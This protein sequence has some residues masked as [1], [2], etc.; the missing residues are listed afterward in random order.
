MIPAFDARGN[1]PPGIHFAGW[2]EF[3]ARFGQTAR[4]RFL[5]T[6]LKAALRALQTAGCP[7]VYVDGSFVTNKPAPGDFDACWSVEGVQPERLDSVLLDF[8]EG[9]AAQKAAFGGELFPAQLPEGVSGRTFLTF[10]Q[11][12]RETGLAKGIVALPL[13]TMDL[14]RVDLEE[15]DLEAE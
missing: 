15:Q 11:T 14:D 12:D 8:S 6:G 7:L 9:R 1:L 13:D 5:L 10:F 2:P 3:A 4:R